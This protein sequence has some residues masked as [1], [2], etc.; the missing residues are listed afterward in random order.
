MPLIEINKPKHVVIPANCLWLPIFFHSVL[1]LRLA[2]SSQ[3]TG[4]Q[5]SQFSQHEMYRFHQFFLC[6]FFY[7]LFNRNAAEKIELYSRL[8]LLVNYVIE[9][10]ES[11][12]PDLMLGA[13]LCE[14]ESLSERFLKI[15]NN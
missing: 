8:N 9:H 15:H 13:Y 11:Q 7:L 12:M 2:T 14:G 4:V 5:S 10:E 3:S 1:I 6:Y